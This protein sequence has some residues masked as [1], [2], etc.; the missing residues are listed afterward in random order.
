MTGGVIT[1]G[2]RTGGG[3]LLG[4]QEWPVRIIRVARCGSM[5]LQYHPESVAV[6]RE[7]PGS[8]LKF[9]ARHPLI[10][11]PDRAHKF[12]AFPAK[13]SDGRSEA[14]LYLGQR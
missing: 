14:E 7:P 11:P 6:P 4:H 12:A 3:P 8:R 9:E 2:V 5:P 1:L 13:A 10:Q